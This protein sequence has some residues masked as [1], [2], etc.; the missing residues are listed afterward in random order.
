M[1]V[2]LRQNLAPIRDKTSAVEDMEDYEE[3]DSNRACSPCGCSWQVC[4]TS[5]PN[6]IGSYILLPKQQQWEGSKMMIVRQISQTL[7]RPKWKNFVRR[8]STSIVS[9]QN[10]RGWKNFITSASIASNK[11]RRGWKNF[12]TSASIASNRKR[13]GQ[14][15]YDPRNYALNFDDGTDIEIDRAWPNTAAQ[16]PAPQHNTRTL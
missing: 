7:A 3:N 13:R 16:L 8:F 6:N 2:K 4:F 9:D 5:H 1:W 15:H 12:I 10:K 14:F 11:K